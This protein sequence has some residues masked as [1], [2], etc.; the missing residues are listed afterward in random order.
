MDPLVIFFSSHPKTPIRIFTPKVLRAREHAPTL[1]P[2]V[3]FTLNSHLS[4]SRSL[5]SASFGALECIYPI[6]HKTKQFLKYKSWMQGLH[7]HN[8]KVNNSYSI[9]NPP[10]KKQH[11]NFRPI[12]HHICVYGNP[13]LIIHSVHLITCKGHIVN[14]GN[15]GH[16]NFNHL[17]IH[18][19]YHYPSCHPNAFWSF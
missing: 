13:T 8:N 17:Y 18:K 2:S 9:N 3:V 1:Y 16:N 10:E 6:N 5:G 19:F 12:L 7:D 4:L 15:S 11:G 14:N